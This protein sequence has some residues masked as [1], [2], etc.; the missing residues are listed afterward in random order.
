ML[1]VL[2]SVA[3]LLFGVVGGCVVGAVGGIVG[4]NVC[5]LVLRACCC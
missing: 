4:G 2:L 5:V 1:V 3:V